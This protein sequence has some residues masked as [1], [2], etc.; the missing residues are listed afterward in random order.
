[1]AR[2]GTIDVRV[3]FADEFERLV[4]LSD[5]VVAKHDAGQLGGPRDSVVIERIRTVLAEI[6]DARPAQ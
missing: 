6:R 3:L 2:I 1:M 4:K 5:E